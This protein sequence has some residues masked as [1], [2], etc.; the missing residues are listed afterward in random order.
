MRVTGTDHFSF[1][2][3]S[4]DDSSSSEKSPSS[5]TLPNVL[6][7]ASTSILEAVVG[8]S[9]DAILTKDLND[10]VTSW[11]PAATALFGYQPEEII[12]HSILRLVPERLH[13]E[14]IGLLQRLRGVERITH[15]VTTRLSR[16]G[17]E[18]QVS[19]SSAAF[20]NQNGQVIGLCEIVR[21]VSAQEQS[22]RARLQ[23]AAIVESSEDAII[24]KNLNGTILTWN[25]AA[26][27]IFGYEEHEIVGKSI[28]TLIPP[29]LRHEEPVIIA[30]LSAGERIEHFETVRVKKNGERM[31]VALTIS[32]IRDTAGR[33]VGA[34]K[35]LRDISDRKRLQTSLLQAE[36]LAATGRMAASIAHEINNPL[37]GL[38]N[39]IYLA[40]TSAENPAEV[41]SL[42]QTA[43]GELVRVAHIAKQTLGYY[44][45]NVSPVNVSMAD[46]VR[47]T[48]RI[49]QPRLKA[50]GI[51]VHYDLQATPS[52][53]MKRGEI[54]QV[55]SNLVANS[56]HAMHGGG[57]L[58]F[59]LYCE[60]KHPRDYVVLDISDSGSGIAPE[61]LKRIFEPF[62]TTR[63]AIG[64][65]I[66]LWVARQFIEGHG[67]RIEVRSSTAPDNHGTTM[68]ICLPVTPAAPI[69]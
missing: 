9:E 26:Q 32:P 7:E 43:E 66:G 2:P 1:S 23:L 41:R 20:R 54:M 31:D 14:E 27:R 11:S 4:P 58:T 48:L 64:T 55:I 67:G 8:S 37:E 30:K 40:R 57:D 49:Y 39:L 13:A 47:D 21:N 15:I 34:S 51:H 44:R 28:L 3:R 68:S 18:F 16:S 17:E 35:I 60:H 62:F 24:S 52:I 10:I 59:K 56:M 53:L 45:E 69:Q 29:E 22:D 63:S 5:A 19:I 33:V 42:L 25:A 6:E 38:L 65:G 50:C 46:L 12:G 61:H 36:K